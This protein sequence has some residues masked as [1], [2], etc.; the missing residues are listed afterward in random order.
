[1]DKTQKKSNVAIDKNS[2]AN[3]NANLSSKRTNLT[4]EAIKCKKILDLDRS[5]RYAGMCTADGKLIASEY[6]KEITPL[7]NESELDFAAKVSAIRSIEREIL[8]S[9]LGRPMYSIA[10]YENVKRATIS[11]ANGK[12]LLVSF[13]RNADDALIIN[14][15]MNEFNINYTLSLCELGSRLAQSLQD[16]LSL[17]KN[18]IEISR[19]RHSTISEDIAENL[20]TI[21]KITL[22]LLHQTHDVLTFVRAS[23]LHI[24]NSYVSDIVNQTIQ[25]IFIPQTV[26][27]N[28]TKNDVKINCDAN[29]LKRVFSNLIV[30]AVQAMNYVGTIN[31]RAKDKDDHV[32]IEFEDTGPGIPENLMGKL[33]EPLFTTKAYGTGL[34]LKT[35]KSVVDQHKG[36]ISVRNNPTTF[37]ITLPNN[38]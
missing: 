3:S 18:I 16:P 27:L 19:K 29:K 2:Q 26:K 23:P 12:F 6:K 17:I 38:K 4:H 5:I 8:S 31:I 22:K 28:L 13:E 37:T 9:K 35:C 32:I 30:N 24:T 36:K 20:D 11:L 15:V 1:M 25:D 34:G 21:E 33:F 10:S 7:I 14:K